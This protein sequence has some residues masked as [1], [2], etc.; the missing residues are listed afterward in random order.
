MAQLILLGLLAA[1]IGFLTGAVK[2]WQWGRGRSNAYR[3]LSITLL[4]AGLWLLLGVVGLFL[5]PL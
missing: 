5:N 3:L 1:A 2:L 4:V